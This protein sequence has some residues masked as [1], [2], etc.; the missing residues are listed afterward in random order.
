MIVIGSFGTVEHGTDLLWTAMPSQY[1]LG[2][3][4]EWKMYKNTIFA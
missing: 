2:A 1:S 3:G 4:H